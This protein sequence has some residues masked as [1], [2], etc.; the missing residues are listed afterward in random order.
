MRDKL[1]VHP[2]V[3]REYEALKLRLAA[4]CAYD[5]VVYTQGKTEFILRVTALARNSFGTR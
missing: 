2:V 4:A 5:R 3:A 1:L